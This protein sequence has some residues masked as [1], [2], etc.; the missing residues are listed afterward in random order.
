MYALTEGWGRVAAIGAAW[1]TAVLIM[2]PIGLSA[3]AWHGA[4][5]LG[6]WSIVFA[7]RAV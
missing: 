1:I 6:L 5:A 2:T 4:L 7:V 3:L